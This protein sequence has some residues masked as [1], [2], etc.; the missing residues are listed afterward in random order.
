MKMDVKVARE[1]VQLQYFIGQITLITNL[2]VTIIVKHGKMNGVHGVKLLQT[3]IMK[4]DLS[5]RC[6]V[7]VTIKFVVEDV[8][9]V[10]LFI[11][12]QKN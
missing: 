2:Y 3:V 8:L 11:M 4:K 1:F 7:H 9:H 12:I 10:H 6:M 5:V